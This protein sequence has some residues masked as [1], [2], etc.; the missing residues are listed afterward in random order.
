MKSDFIWLDGELVPYDQANMHVL[1]P[2]VHYGPG[3][4]EGIRC[5]ETPRGTAVFRLHE[6]LK[7]FIN[8]IHILGFENTGYN[9]EDL[10]EAV[11]LTIRANGFRECY[12][13]PFMYLEG[14]LGLNLDASRPIIAI[15]T[16]EW[17]TY[18]GQDALEKGVRAM[19]SSFTR[20]HPNINMT[21]AKIGGQ[22]VNSMLAKTLAKRLG[23]DEAI[24]LDPEGY[25]AECS[26]QNLFIVRDGVIMTTPRASILEG[27]TRDAVITLA[28]DSG[29]EITEERFSRDQLYIADE[30]FVTGTATEVAAVREIDFR[31]IGVGRMGPVT[32]ELQ[33]AFFET[34]R[35]NGPR[36]EEWLDYVVPEIVT[37]E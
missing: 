17:G 30:V 33:T 36:S 7:R 34:V 23:F 5:Y 22:Y 18:L 19:V 11:H 28:R 27:I 6:H 20:L 21:K 31:T 1:S 37:A 32:R 12:I 16:W 29:Y 13:R 10:H 3:V 15:A 26:G 24:M 9:P 4:F 35:G 8:S 25:V 2:T 14:P